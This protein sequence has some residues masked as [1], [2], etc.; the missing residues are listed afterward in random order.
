MINFDK[1]LKIT[2]K[3]LQKSSIDNS[4]FDQIES[5]IYNFGH[6]LKYNKYKQMA[7]RRFHFF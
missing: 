4:I 7:Q 2:F 6:C 5:F 3:N 1:N